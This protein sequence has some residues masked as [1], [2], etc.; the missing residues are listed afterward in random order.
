MTRVRRRLSLGLLT[1]LTAAACS[2]PQAPAPPTESGTARVSAASKVRAL[3]VAAN[4]GV[5]RGELLV[6]VAGVIANHGAKLVANN[7]AAVVANN[8]AGVI[9]NHG[10]GYS[11]VATDDLLEPAAN[12]EVVAFDLAGRRL[13]GASGRTDAQGRFELKGLGSSA[14]VIVLRASLQRDGRAIA[15]SS[16]VAAPRD[17]VIEGVKVDPATSLVARKVA[18]LI[19]RDAVEPVT[20]RPDGLAAAAKAIAASLGGA[21]VTIA[22]A[23]GNAQAAETLDTLF[24]QNEGL[25]GEVDRAAGAAVARALPTAPPATPGGPASGPPASAAPL[26]A[27][28]PGVASGEPKAEPSP[29]AEPS[30]SAAPSPNTTA[31]PSIAPSVRPSEQPASSPSPVP[32]SGV[33]SVTTLAGG[34]FGEGDGIGTAAQFKA[35]SDVDLATNGELIVLDADSEHLRRVT[36]TG[37]VTTWQLPGGDHHHVEDAESIAVDAQGR[38]YAP[39]SGAGGPA[40]WRYTDGGAAVNFAA[41]PAGAAS[42]ELPRGLDFNTGGSLYYAIVG[43]TEDTLRAITAA[44]AEGPVLNAG[45]LPVVVQGSRAIVAG[46]DGILYVAGDHRIFKVTPQGGVATLAGND[47]GYAEGTGTE[48]RFDGISDLALAPDGSLIVA[49]ADNNRIRRV[50]TAGV[51]TTVAGDGIEGFRNGAAN[52]AR[53]S[54]PL[55][56]AVAADGTVYVAD[57]GNDAIRKFTLPQ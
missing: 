30:P 13:D 18:A 34:D 52:T 44:G 1:A 6:P 45:G 38:V 16:V 15:L 23:G 9:A 27:V 7:S 46:P 40:V 47:D 33:W 37:K 11:V 57:E 36:T 35:P 42:I 2:S 50:T 48:A 4:K 10:A 19:E 39:K 26:V 43:G 29:A 3:P 17:G 8:A 25:R 20:L 28:G 12:V 24:A 41:L 5:L 55:G 14:A 31:A 49:D 54:N 51:V 21:E 53:F 56:V 32:S 22:V